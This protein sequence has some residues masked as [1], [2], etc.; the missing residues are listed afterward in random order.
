MFQSQFWCA[1][2]LAREK[3][4]GHMS[5]E[6]SFENHIER[7][8]DTSIWSY[9]MTYP[10][11]PTAI[12]GMYVLYKLGKIQNSIFPLFFSQQSYISFNSPNT[13][14]QGCVSGRHLIILTNLES[15]CG[16]VQLQSVTKTCEN[17]QQLI[18]GIYLHNFNS[19]F[20][21][22]LSEPVGLDGKMLATMSVLW[23][24]SLHHERSIGV[25]INCQVFWRLE[26]HLV[27][28]ITL[29]V[30]SNSYQSG[31]MRF[32]GSTVIAYRNLLHRKYSV[33][34]VVPS[35]VASQ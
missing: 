6:Y 32:L 10:V 30:S 26:V 31:F 20:D 15:P 28:T 11:L 35:I 24:L 33:M 22:L 1:G 3:S 16:N 21:Y 13:P 27:V 9:L 12:K 29:D 4:P 19:T 7:H 5:D 25:G 18:L 14:S 8:V 17:I 34:C 23:C 2:F